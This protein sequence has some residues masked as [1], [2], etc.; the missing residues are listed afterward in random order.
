M[1]SESVCQVARSWVDVGSLHT[2]LFGVVYV[3]CGDF[4]D[5]SEKGTVS[6]HQ[7]FWQNTKRLSLL[8]HSTP[9]IW[10]PVTYSYFQKWN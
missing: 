8:N 5:G 7:N 4:H 6:V 2:R 3:T 9:L 10:H 1:S